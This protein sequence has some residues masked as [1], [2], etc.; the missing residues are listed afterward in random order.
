MKQ[1]DTRK[2]DQQLGLIVLA[3]FLAVL[4]IQGAMLFLSIWL[5]A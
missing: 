5:G 2:Y 4:L 3:A 1:R